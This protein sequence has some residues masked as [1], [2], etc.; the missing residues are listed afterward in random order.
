MFLEGDLKKPGFIN[1]KGDQGVAL[2]FNT[3]LLPNRLLLFRSTHTTKFGFYAIFFFGFSYSEN[4]T[5]TENSMERAFK[6]RIYNVEKVMG[7]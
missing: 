3:S 2:N 5:C 4:K 6:G 1:K 7:F